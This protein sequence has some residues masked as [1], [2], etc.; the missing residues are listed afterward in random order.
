[1]I[2]G[3]QGVPS[4]SPPPTV[5]DVINYTAIWS[6]ECVCPKYKALLCYY[7]GPLQ[8]KVG[9]TIELVVL[10]QMRRVSLRN[11]VAFALLFCMN[12]CCL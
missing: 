11:S 9:I 3:G 2:F 1:M 12:E 4:L 8:M 7:T 5:D 6:Q 10:L